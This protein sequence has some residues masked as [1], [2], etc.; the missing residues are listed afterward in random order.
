MEKIT[1]KKAVTEQI[2]VMLENNI[3]NEYGNESFEGWCENGDVF[4][5]S[6]PDMPDDFYRACEDLMERVSR[7]VDNLTYNHLAEF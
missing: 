3:L 6:Y 5:N 4:E 1:P 7:I 2:I